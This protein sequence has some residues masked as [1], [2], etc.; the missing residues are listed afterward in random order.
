MRT[1][2]W[3]FATVWQFARLI[4]VFCGEYHETK[5]DLNRGC[6]HGGLSV[7]LLNLSVEGRAVYLKKGGRF[8]LVAGCDFQCFFNSNLFKFLEFQSRK[9][10]LKE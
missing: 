2:V 7:H 3:Q 10:A 5:Y 6:N 1:L 8:G 4:I 9:L